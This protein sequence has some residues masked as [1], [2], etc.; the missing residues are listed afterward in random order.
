MT[1]ADWV[2]VSAATLL[3]GYLYLYFW[4]PAEHGSAVRIW[5]EGSA[6][7]HVSLNEDREIA[8]HGTL[9]TSVI[10]IHDGQVR[11]K[12]SPCK[13]KLCIHRGWLTQSGETAAC[14][15][16]RVVI[17]VVGGERAF[18]AVNF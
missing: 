5:T 15:P 18:D 10:E 14:L 17:Q 7:S 1:R 4:I 13:N 8:V 12:S 3:V 2:V 9:G 6:P 16:N 11:F